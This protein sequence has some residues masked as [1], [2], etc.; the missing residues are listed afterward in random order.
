MFSDSE[1][2][3]HGLGSLMKLFCQRPIFMAT[4]S[5][6]SIIWGIQKHSRGSTPAASATFAN[7]L[8]CE[9]KTLFGIFLET[10]IDNMGT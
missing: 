2:L 4:C 1:F 3:P 8:M 9:L 6:A 5:R 10:L 7:R